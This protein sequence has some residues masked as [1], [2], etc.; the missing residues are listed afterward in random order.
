MEISTRTYIYAQNTYPMIHKTH[1]LSTLHPVL[2]FI[3]NFPVIN[4]LFIVNTVTIKETATKTVGK[5]S[6]Y[7]FKLEPVGN[8]P[9]SVELV[10][11]FD[12]P[13]YIYTGSTCT[14]IGPATCSFIGNDNFTINNP[15][16]TGYICCSFKEFEITGIINPN[17]TYPF[18]E[19]KFT[20]QVMDGSSLLE[21]WNQILRPKVGS[22]EYLPLHLSLPAAPFML[23]PRTVTLSQVEFQLRNTDSAILANSKIIIKFPPELTFKGIPYI[24]THNFPF[25]PNITSSTYPWLEI[26]IDDLPINSLIH[27]GVGNILGPYKLGQTESFSISIAPMSASSGVQQFKLYLEAKVDITHR[28]VFSSFNVESSSH[29]TS[30]LATYTFSFNTEDKELVLNDDSISFEIPNSIQCDHTSITGALGLSAPFLYKGRLLISEYYIV[31]GQ[32]VA[33]GI[34]CQFT[35]QCYNP[36]LTIT[37][38]NY[39]LQFWHFPDDWYLYKESGGSPLTINQ[40][41]NYLSDAVVTMSDYRPLVNNSFTFTLTRT[42]SYNS[43]DLTQII[44]CVPDEMINTA[45]SVEWIAGNI[46]ITPILSIVGQEI[47]IEG[48]SELEQSFTFKI[49]NIQNPPLSTDDI[50]FYTKTGSSGYDSEEG[51]TNILHISCDFPCQTCSFQIQTYYCLSCYPQN[52]PLFVGTNLTHRDIIL[53]NYQCIHECPPKYFKNI[54]DL[55]CECKFIYICIYIYIYLL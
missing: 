31:P 30:E 19:I 53:Y 54:P 36:E 14:T 8:L 39:V 55:L 7:I 51:Y 1:E 52:H 38:N 20:M 42:A 26:E 29:M 24:A 12:A 37:T 40:M 3:F 43:L 25:T 44:I 9:S 47:L 4:L 28:G 13:A 49:V 35:I 27:F 50:I 21:E 2:G 16:P 11:S 15:Y 10:I 23:S 32:S 5:A 22:T 18:S 33:A 41:N 45:D 17:F 34:D 6:T 46:N 48:I